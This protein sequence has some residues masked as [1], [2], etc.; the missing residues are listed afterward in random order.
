[1]S[2]IRII[3]GLTVRKVVVRP[4]TWKSGANESILFSDGRTILELREPPNIEADPD[5]RTMEI[6][7]NAPYWTQLS[8]ERH[9]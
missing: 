2:D 7:Q 6:F 1:M 4:S 9:D 3:E 8:V 5:F